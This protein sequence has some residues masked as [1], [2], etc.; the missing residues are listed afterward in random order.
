[1]SAS[2]LYHILQLPEYAEQN[3]IK[4]QYRRL[5]F[6]YHPDQHQGGDASQKMKSINFAYS[7]L[8]DPLKKRD[9]DKDL[10]KNRISAPK[11][12]GLEELYFSGLQYFSQGD[13]FGRREQ[14]VKDKKIKR[15]YTRHQLSSYIKAR[16]NLR[17]FTRIYKNSTMVEDAK[18]KLDILNKLIK[19]YQDDLRKRPM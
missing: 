11:E 12:K 13:I 16:E 17:I 2:N 4:K 15:E 1:M 7:I 19:I 9:Y 10:Q 3:D 8:S 5:A 6:L 18:K 14:I